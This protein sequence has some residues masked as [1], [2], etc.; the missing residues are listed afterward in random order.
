MKLMLV[1]PRMKHKTGDSPIGICSIAAYLKK[2]TDADVF[3][4]DTTFDISFEHIKE[5]F[6][7]DKPDI[8]G[9]YV[10]TLMCNDA[11][12][13]AKIAKKMG[14]FVLIGGPHPTVMPESVKNCSDLI[15]LGEGETTIKDVLDHFETR[16]FENVNGIIFKNKTEWLK[17]PKRDFI[18]NLDSLEYPD[19]DLVDMNK[20]LNLWHIFDSYNPNIKGANIIA[21]RGCPYNCS[22]C[23]P[24]LRALFG[25]VVRHRSPENVIDELK[26]L[27][28]KFSIQAFFL[29][30]D[31]FNI[32][33]D[34][35]KKFC[36]LLKK[37]KLGLLWACNVRVNTLKNLKEVKM[38]YDSG[39]RIVHIGV[40][41]GSQRILNEIYQKGIKLKDV[42]VAID[43]LNKIGI[44]SLC[45]F[46]L[47]A[48]TETKEEIEQTIKFAVSL[49][50]TE[51]TASIATPLPG[52]K[53]LETM[54][55][56]YKISNDF[57]KFDYYNNR[58]FEDKN[59]SFEELK[60]YQRKLL[61]KFYI[62]PKRW[63]YI[64]KHIT[65]IKGWK[66]M[67]LKLKRFF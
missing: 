1:F 8:V 3:V 10:D 55:K 57:S 16:N 25:D 64:F 63:F 15:V 9:I 62:H 17:T 21:S 46:M 50:A 30:D 20:Y 36:S 66:K 29:Q 67:F 61:F 48:P 58:A 33:K 32:N 53:L 47:G 19:F 37:E 13:I 41:S 28:K 11:I 54:K 49:N 59:L 2:H 38:M 23:Q 44:K 26:I 27:K 60:R 42:P 45:F 14:F 43:N 12:K 5:R 34:W 7:K 22:F 6:R 18:Q 24:T 52:T 31:T 39:L 35:V 4:L 65:H 51:I 40:E 56:K